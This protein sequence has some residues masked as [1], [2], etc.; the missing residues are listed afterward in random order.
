MILITSANYIH[1]GL[2]SEFGRIPPSMLPVQNKRLYDHQYNI[3]NQLNNKLDYKENIFL[4]LPVDYVLPEADK[5]MI[6]KLNINV[7]REDSSQTLVSSIYDS[8][9][10]S[11][12]D[13]DSVRILF[14]DT[15]FNCLPTDLDSYLYGTPED[16]YKWDYDNSEYAYSGFFSFS[17]KQKLKQALSQCSNFADVIKYYDLK[18]I[19]S[20]GWLDFGLQNTYYRS[21]SKFTT[22]RSFNS[23]DITKFSVIK[24]SE[25]T[26]K[27]EAESSWLLNVPSDMKHY[28]P[29]V[30]S[31]FCNGYEI[32]YLYLSSLASIYV[33][34]ELPQNIWNRVIDSCV[35]YLCDEYS[36]KADN[37]KEIAHLNNELFTNKTLSRLNKYDLDLDRCFTLN[38]NKLPSIRCIIDELDRYIKKDDADSVSLMHGDFC[39]S[40]ILYD[41]KSSSVK[42]IDPRGISGD[43]KQLSSYGD[44][45][46]DVAKL[47]HSLI[48]KYDF[49]IAGRFDYKESSTHDLNFKLFCTDNETDKYFIKQI[50]DRLH[51]SVKTIY[52]VMINLFLSMIPLHSDNR[53][54]QKAFLAN[55]L[56]L[57]M[58]FKSL[59][60]N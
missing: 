13:S 35:D 37:A 29:A 5:I 9:N 58:E 6:D 49:I 57:Y 14:G 34:G 25:D 10:S 38:E 43:G 7:I 21:I 4:S 19:E 33:F 47:A 18:G 56:R 59:C 22:Q 1:Y 54:R 28:T 16:S 17:D 52:A 15:L 3:V 24:K 48:G 44:I 30:Y 50:S 41:F 55:S 53:L 27:M 40:N 45:R 31:T 20:D 26:K 46:Y 51:I 8:I 60:E 23:L 2:A 42:A 39:F 12:D 32:E 36:H 11:N